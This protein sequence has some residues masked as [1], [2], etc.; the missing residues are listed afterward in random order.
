MPPSAWRRWCSSSS[1]WWRSGSCREAKAGGDGLNSFPSGLAQQ[2]P[3]RMD[4]GSQAPLLGNPP[5][6]PRELL[7]FRFVERG[8]E[9]IL[10]LPGDANEPLHASRPAS[11]RC[12]A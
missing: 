10:M 5:E 4:A 7:P 11:V 8:A 12:S 6:I 3:S 2:L 1:R 9:V